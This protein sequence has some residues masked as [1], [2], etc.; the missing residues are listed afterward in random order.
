M[1]NINA[2]DAFSTWKQSKRFFKAE[3]WANKKKKQ[4]S[5]YTCTTELRLGGEKA[6]NTFCYSARRMLSG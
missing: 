6:I 4:V 3:F 2:F 5:A 1:H